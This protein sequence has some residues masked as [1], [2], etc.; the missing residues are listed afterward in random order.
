MNRYWIAG[1]LIMLLAQPLVMPSV[2]DADCPNSDRVYCGKTRQEANN[3]HS[4]FPVGQCSDSWGNCSIKNCNAWQENII[5][6]CKQELGAE[7]GV[8]KYSIV[9]PDLDPTYF[10]Y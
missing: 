8:V 10:E 6:Q 4:R 3:N 2:A 5:R 1:V 9:S 7:H